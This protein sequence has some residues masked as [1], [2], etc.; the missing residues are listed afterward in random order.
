MDSRWLRNG[1]TYLLILVAIGAI[2][3][4]LFAR[5]SSSNQIDISTVIDMAKNNQLATI[6]VKGDS[7]TIITKTGDK[8]TR[9]K[10]VL[11]AY[12]TSSLKRG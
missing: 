4:T 11:T 8:Y 10:R 5:S 1:F 9:I 3:Y 7:L 2:F 12:W 6:E